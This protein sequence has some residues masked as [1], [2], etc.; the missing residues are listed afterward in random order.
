MKKGKETI[1]K[2]FSL[3]GLVGKIGRKINLARNKLKFLHFAEEMTDLRHPSKHVEHNNSLVSFSFYSYMI[4]LAFK[5]VC[6]VLDQFL[7][8]KGYLGFDFPHTS[9]GNM[10]VACN[11]GK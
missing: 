11:E 6:F 8:F 10:W 3:S 7:V 4:M 1:G 2:H 9:L 5:C